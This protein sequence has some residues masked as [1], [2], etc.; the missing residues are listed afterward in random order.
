MIPGGG[1]PFSVKLTAVEEAMLPLLEETAIHGIS[2]IPDSEEAECYVP[3][4]T[5]EQV[6]TGK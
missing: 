2:G 6:S 3:N 1:P 4:I 5:T